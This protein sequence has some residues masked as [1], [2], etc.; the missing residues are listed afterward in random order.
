MAEGDDEKLVREVVRDIV[1]AVRKA[2]EAA[3]RN[4]CYCAVETAC[5]FNTAAPA[6]WLPVALHLPCPKKHPPTCRHIAR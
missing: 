5:L 2:A 4:R 6:H 1:Q 3:E